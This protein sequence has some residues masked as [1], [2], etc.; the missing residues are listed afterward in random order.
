[1]TTRPGGGTSTVL[2][3][4]DNATNVK[5]MER[6]FERRP[7]V[8]LVVATRGRAALELAREHRPGLVLLDLDLPDMSGEDVLRHLRSDPTTADAAVV[9]VSGDAAPEQPA[10]LR[11]LGATDYLTKPFDVAR[12]L[13]LVD[14]LSVGPVD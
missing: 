6:I 13:Q 7:Q 3:V 14:D 11:G 9:M 1:M 2:Y 5:L 12:L 8:S 4:E 10:R